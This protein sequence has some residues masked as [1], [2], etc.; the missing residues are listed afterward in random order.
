LA[1]EARIPFAPVNHPTDLF[2]DSHMNQAGQLAATKTPTGQYVKLPK[3]PVQ[4]NG[5]SFPLRSQPPAI[6]EGS[7]D[8]L[9]RIGTSEEE[10]HALIEK[11]VIEH[12]PTK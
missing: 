3:L 5:E 10:M 1:E 9:R 6:G 2:E 12:D 4:L 8:L 11:N 7:A